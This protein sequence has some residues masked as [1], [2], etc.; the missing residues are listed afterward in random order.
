MKK[1]YALVFA[2]ALL[3]CSNINAQPGYDLSFLLTN[4]NTTDNAGICS[5]SANNIYIAG[6]LAAGTSV[7]LNPGPGTFTVSAGT[8]S[9]IYFAKYDAGGNFLWGKQIYAT[10]NDGVRAR[11]IKIKGANF[12]LG[13]TIEGTADFDPG[14][15]ADVH[16]CS[17][18]GEAC[19]LKFDLDGNY[20][21]GAQNAGAYS[22]CTDIEIDN[23]DA[24]Y[25]AAHN[26]GG[27]H[28]SYVKKFTVTGAL[29]WTR[30]LA[31]G[32]GSSNGLIAGGIA[33]DHSGGVYVT[34]HFNQ[35]VNFGGGTTYPILYVSGTYYSSQFFAKY[36]TANTF[37]F[38]RVMC[39]FWEY[40][41]VE[42]S[43]D[44]PGEDHYNVDFDAANNQ[45][46]VTGYVGGT[47]DFDFGPGTATLN[48]PSGVHKFIAKYTPAGGYVWLVNFSC[49]SQSSLSFDASGNLYYLGAFGSGT[50]D[51]HPT[52]SNPVLTA[53]GT[54]YNVLLAKY[55]P[56][57]NLVWS[58]NIG[59]TS[60]SNIYCY[61]MFANSSY[62]YI[63]GGFSAAADFDMTGGVVS[64]NGSPGKAFVVR[65]GN[66]TAAPSQPVSI[67]GATALCS[68]AAAS[69]SITPVSGATS[70]TWSLPGGWTGSSSTTSINAT[71]GAGSGN[72]TVTANNS[73]GSSAVQTLAVTA[74]NPVVSASASS[75]S[76][77]AGDSTSLTGSGATNY[78]WMPGSLS[79]TSVSVSPAGNTTYTVI[80][81]D[82]NGCADTNTVAVTVNALPSVS[83]NASSSTICAGA[84]TSL[85]GNGA[86]TYSWMPGSLSG[87]SVSVSPT[88][89]TTYTVSGTDANGCADT[90]TVSV[91][92]NALPTISANAS[93]SSICTGASTSLTANGATTYSWMPGS[94]SGTPV[95]VSPTGNTTY[96]VSGTDA[97][98]CVNTETVSVTVNALPNVS[99]VESQSTVCINWTPLTLSA[100]SPAGGTYSGTGVSGN[101]FDP[102]SAGTGTWNIVYTYSDGNGCADS[103]TQ[104]ITVDLC[105]GSLADH[106]VSGINIFPNP[107]SD[108]L[109]I[110]CGTIS[111]NEEI[112]VLDM[113]GQALLAVKLEGER[114]T[115]DMKTFPAGVYF[116]QIK[117]DKALVTERVIKQ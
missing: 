48:V 20:I 97:N 67:S 43:G 44:S 1:L 107:F 23:A 54:G 112:L 108:E 31:G 113:L 51:M 37:Q 76:I 34:G 74:G 47:H 4:Y 83:A 98:G 8:F 91:T 14:P 85:T 81:T 15:A 17:G 116:V 77:C 93:A 61:A 6:T 71:A 22:S 35:S 19:V 7:D 78:S 53:S 59:T 66:C 21:W 79:G 65:Y 55:D 117:N 105:T 25:M 94:L 92:V 102:A 99:Y 50:A 114:T 57:G 72:I 26:H 89:S 52:M 103:I 82:A 101:Q 32:S 30:Y 100:G 110:A 40:N 28:S 115:I 109:T 49:S 13:A 104:Q 41:G 39:H 24:V 88:S 12:Y 86:T 70:Y 36:D 33:V 56:V 84:S 64:L 106:A 111:G 87:I 16:A 80:G 73:C 2:S 58:G 29:R 5:D 75:P 95:A 60:S 69:Y 45:V 3:L 63:Y 27:P 38:V 62:L 42:H 11:L 68:G 18:G 10:T 90:G 46:T 96:T 9:R